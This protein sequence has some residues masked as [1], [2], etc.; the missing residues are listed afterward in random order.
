MRVFSCTPCGLRAGKHFLILYTETPEKAPFKMKGLR[1]GRGVFL[2]KDAVWGR[3]LIGKWS[4]GLLM[5]P[6]RLI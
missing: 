5:D 6:L 3:G 2:K 1:A 4:N